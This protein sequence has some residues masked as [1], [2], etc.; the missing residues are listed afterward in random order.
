A[1]AYF[2]SNLRIERTCSRRKRLD[3][4]S[5]AGF[6]KSSLTIW[7]TVTIVLLTGLATIRM[8]SYSNTSQL[9]VLVATNLA[10]DIKPFTHSDTFSEAIPKRV[11]ARSIACVVGTYCGVAPAFANACLIVIRPFLRNLLN[12]RHRHAFRDIRNMSSQ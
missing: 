12:Y 5:I 11:F 7:C 10:F 9:S 8:P 4:R 6:K 1:S 2:S 3:S